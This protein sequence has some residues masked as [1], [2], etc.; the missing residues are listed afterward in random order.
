[1]INTQTQLFLKIQFLTFLLK[2]LCFP[3]AFFKYLCEFIGKNISILKI[4]YD[5]E[6]F[7]PAEIKNETRK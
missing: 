1:M 7:Y 6:N 5:I 2:I 3:F 4:R